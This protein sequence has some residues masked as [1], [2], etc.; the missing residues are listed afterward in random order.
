MFS[1][2]GRETILRRVF[3]MSQVT[4]VS[5]SGPDVSLYKLIFK[6]KSSPKLLIY[7]KYA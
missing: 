4:L 7:A 1:S 2:T 6:S 5:V 3:R